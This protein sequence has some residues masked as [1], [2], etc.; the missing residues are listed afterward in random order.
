MKKLQLLYVAPEEG[1]TVEDIL[2]HF[3]IRVRALLFGHEEN[4]NPEDTMDEEALSYSPIAMLLSN[5]ET[6]EWNV[7]CEYT[8][9]EY[10]RATLTLDVTE[11]PPRGK[12]MAT[13]IVRFFQPVNDKLRQGLF[14]RW[15][16]LNNHDIVR[17]SMKG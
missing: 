6:Y 16:I 12:P 5:M 4:G 10:V 3:A 2:D 17:C 9:G 15:D 8:Q 11:E 14:I 7:P 13:C 1:R